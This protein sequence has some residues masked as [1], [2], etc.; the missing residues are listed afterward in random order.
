MRDMANA[1]LV[2]SIAVF[3]AGALALTLVRPRSPGSP[4]H[5]AGL[6]LLALGLL[7]F[8]A[9]AIGIAADTTS[10]LLRLI[11]IVSLSAGLVVAAVGCLFIGVSLVRSI[12]GIPRGEASADGRR[13]RRARQAAGL[14][15]LLAFTGL[16]AYAAVVGALGSDALIHPKPD[17]DC[18][19]PP[20]IY[21]AINYS[22]GDDAQVCSDHVGTAGDQVITS[23]GVRIGGW[24]IPAANG[25]G[26][27]G[28]TVVLV[29]G[30][31]A[32]KSEVLKYAVPFHPTF[33]VVA[34]D[35]RGGG[36]SSMSETT[37]GLREKLDLEAV[38]DW[39]ERTKHPVHIAVMGN[40]MG[41]A[42]AVLAA[43]EDQR[44]EA[45]ILDSTHAHISEVLA[46][47]LEL[48]DG[49]P[50]FPGAPA[51]LAGISAR[52]G[53]DL[54]DSDPA[55]AIPALGH[56]PL[57]IIHGTAD[58]N[59]LP[60]RSAAVNYSV[61]QAAGVPVELHMCPDA[62]HGKVIDKCPTEWGRWSIQ[63]L[64]R[65]FGLPTPAAF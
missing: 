6:G 51:I 4:I 5:G 33:N 7:G 2:V 46:Q 63:F 9:G 36:R 24:Y 62:T 19:T 30:W 61:A 47:T 18:L 37:S 27:S 20:W 54:L 25:V 48:E 64:D 10:S 50:A 38:I 57:L 13:S 41:G 12:L 34:F 65:A 32:N 40:S 42:T 55:L 59:D 11:S 56:R 22:I 29:H 31:H 49:V 39:L 43:A 60:E 45:L 15:G 26:A 17:P 3:A 8:A 1:V 28:P 16:A 52:T 23:D 44:I 53:L 35:Q 14:V 58:A 21:E